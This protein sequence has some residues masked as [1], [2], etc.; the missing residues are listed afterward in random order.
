MV[1]TLLNVSISI[2]VDKIWIAFGLVGKRRDKEKAL[3]KTGTNLIF[4]PIIGW[5]GCPYA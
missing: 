5:E 1:E 2:I 3:E 4:E